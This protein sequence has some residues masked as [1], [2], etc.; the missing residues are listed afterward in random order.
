MYWQDFWW[1][2]ITKTVNKPQEEE[3]REEFAKESSYQ[4]IRPKW[5]VIIEEMYNQSEKDVKK[6]ELKLLT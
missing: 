3:K 5:A 6:L 4:E 2:K 1:V